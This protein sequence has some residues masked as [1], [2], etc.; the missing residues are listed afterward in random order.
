MEK[1][2]CLG[3]L[4]DGTAPPQVFK[5]FDEIMPGVGWTRGC[6]SVTRAKAPYPLRGGGKVVYHEFCYGL[7]I[8]VPSRRIPKIWNQKG[9]G[10]AY[11][12]SDFDNQILLRFHL[13]AERGLYCGTRGIGRV[14]LDFWCV[15]RAIK[16][17]TQLANIYNR[18]PHSSC[19]QRAP[20]VYSLSQ[21][22]PDGALATLRFELLREGIQTAEAAMVVS[23]AMDKPAATLG[24]E[25]TAK[26]RAVLT[27]RINVC[28]QVNG[29]GYGLHNG[30]Q[31]RDARLFGT[32][33]EVS[34]KLRRN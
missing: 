25:L 20:T 14:C 11:F 31:D 34:K 4:S 23:E 16:A 21:P 27:R 7:G 3:I 22:G 29:V 8:P 30:W 6:H 13:F 15:P 12:R 2:M 32:A 5:M 17:R 33:A 19:A 28:R 24:G 9:P 26:C 18:W 1:A 10:T